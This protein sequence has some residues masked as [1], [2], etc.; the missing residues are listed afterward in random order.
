MTG[1]PCPN[2]QTDNDSFAEVWASREDTRKTG[3]WDSQFFF[4]CSDCGTEYETFEEN[5]AN[6]DPEDIVDT[7][8]H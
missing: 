8:D 2:C 3:Q 1:C 4:C 6:I 5:P 7:T